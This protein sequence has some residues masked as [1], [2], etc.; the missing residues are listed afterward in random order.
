MDEV[1]SD[2]K[3]VMHSSL[4]KSGLFRISLEPFKKVLSDKIAENK[5][6]ILKT[7]E[8][9]TCEEVGS[10]KNDFTKIKEKLKERPEN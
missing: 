7:I 4:E 9:Q 10:L 5:K 6:K 3:D 1:V 8:N 2:E